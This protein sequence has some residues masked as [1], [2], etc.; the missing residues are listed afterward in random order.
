MTRT[1]SPPCRAGVLPP[2]SG[3]W[4]L[5]AL[6]SGVA[7]AQTVGKYSIVADDFVRMQPHEKRAFPTRVGANLVL[8]ETMQTGEAGVV[9]ILLGE[10]MLVTLGAGGNFG[11]VAGGRGGASAPAPDAALELGYGLLR[12]FVSRFAE[13]ELEIRLR[14]APVSIRIAGAEAGVETL[15]DGTVRITSFGGGGP[16][17][18]R[19]GTGAWQSLPVGHAI[20]LGRPGTGAVAEPPPVGEE[21]ENQLL[22][23]TRPIPTLQQ[24]RPRARSPEDYAPPSLTP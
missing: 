2:W 20:L 12:A 14:E 23:R 4:V 7:G 3:V 22:E 16:V 19:E 17:R 5:L 24:R 9:Q 13:E 21:V 1:S 18:W 11:V 8:G 6:W 15:S 10:G